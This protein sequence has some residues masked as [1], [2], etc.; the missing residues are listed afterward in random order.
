MRSRRG[1][2]LATAALTMLVAPAGARPQAGPMVSIC[3]QAGIRWIAL[4]AGGEDDRSPA[5]D[6]DKACH[7]GCPRKKQRRG[8]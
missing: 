3:S 1:L 2:I 8:H 5:A 4:P 6:C 7:F